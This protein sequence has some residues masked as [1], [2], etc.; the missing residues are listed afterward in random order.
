VDSVLRL[1]IIGWSAYWNYWEIERESLTTFWNVIYSK[2]R[3][4]GDVVGTYK[5]KVGLF[6]TYY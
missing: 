1:R 4:D 3:L 6:T 5:I 2:N